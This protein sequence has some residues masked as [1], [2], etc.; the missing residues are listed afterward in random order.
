M[1]RILFEGVLGVAQV[2]AGPTL[3]RMGGPEALAEA[4]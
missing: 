2:A 1:N 4:A 3:F